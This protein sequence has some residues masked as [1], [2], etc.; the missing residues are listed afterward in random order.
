[1]AGTIIGQAFNARSS[2]P[3]LRAQPRIAEIEAVRVPARLAG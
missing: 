2:E 1:M 3:A